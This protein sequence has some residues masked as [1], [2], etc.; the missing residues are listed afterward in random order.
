MITVEH[1]VERE[2]TREQRATFIIARSSTTIKE[3][4]DKFHAISKKECELQQ[5][6][7]TNN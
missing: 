2:L 1:E 7:E 6:V 5:P 3:A 4:K